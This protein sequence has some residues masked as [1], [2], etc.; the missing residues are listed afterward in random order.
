MTDYGTFSTDDLLEALAYAGRHP[1]PELIRACLARRDALTPILLEWVDESLDPDYGTAWSD[2]NP[3]WYRSLH[4]AHLLIAFGEEAALPLFEK[5]VRRDLDSML[6]ETLAEKLHFYGPAA[7]PMLSGILD[8]EDVSVWQR[9]LAAQE[10]QS[11]AAA[12]P[13]ER[14]HVVSLLRS[15][16]PTPDEAGRP[17]GAETTNE[18]DVRFWS[19][20]ASSLAWLRDEESR[21]LIEALYEHDLIDDW[22]ADDLEM[23]W[24]AETTGPVR[25]PEEYDIVSD[26]EDRHR[27]A[28]R[29]RQPAEPWPLEV[30][31]GDDG[32]Y[33]DGDT[34]VRDEPKVGRNDPCPCGSG[35]KYK[36]CCGP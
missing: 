20:L 29:E 19:T 13:S 17:A 18:D 21:P 34:F 32:H 31:S 2:D 16:L 12:H 26:Y 7:V 27:R 1:D 8:D 11:I 10:L 22:L 25:K 6:I 5:H 30:E 3:R 24:G 9:E 35:K 28:Q 4:A 14:D 36:R 23:L 33:V 15:H